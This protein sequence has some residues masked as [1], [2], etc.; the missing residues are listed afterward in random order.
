MMLGRINFNFLANT[1]VIILY[2][3]SINDIGI[4]SSKLM[5]SSFLDINVINVVLRPFDIFHTIMEGF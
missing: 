1:L 2:I 4:Y 5:G 3:R